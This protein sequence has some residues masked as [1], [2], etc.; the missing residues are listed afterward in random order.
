[1]FTVY[2]KYGST[3]LVSATFWDAIPTY[4]FSD[5]DALKTITSDRFTFMKDV[6]AVRSPSILSRNKTFLTNTTISMKPLMYMGI[7]S[8]AKKDR[9]GN[10]IV[11]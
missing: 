8:L 1:M 5:A 7:V 11:P 9:N 4:W 3:C 2:K 6:E 10:V